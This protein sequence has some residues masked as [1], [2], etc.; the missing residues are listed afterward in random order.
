MV[1]LKG[2]AVERSICEAFF[3]NSYIGAHQTK[4]AR[5][6]LGHS[7]Q[8]YIMNARV[9]VF[10]GP[11]EYSTSSPPSAEEWKRHPAHNAHI[12]EISAC[13]P[14]LETLGCTDSKMGNLPSLT[15]TQQPLLHIF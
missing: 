6:I 1:T 15:H 13:G 11:P 14:K 9:G 5:I 4:S 12:Y 10:D 8:N 7:R 2:F 3:L